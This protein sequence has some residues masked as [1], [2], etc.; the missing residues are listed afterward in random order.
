MPIGNLLR[1]PIHIRRAPAND[2][3]EADFAIL[4]QH[5]CWNE[6][7]FSVFVYR[8]QQDHELPVAPASL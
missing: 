4:L 3:R 2:E 5:H 8:A 6:I 1:V 7:A